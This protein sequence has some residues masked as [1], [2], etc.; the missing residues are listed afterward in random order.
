MELLSELQ[1]TY[2]QTLPYFDL[3]EGKLGLTYGPGKWNVQEL[4]HHIVDAETVMYDRIRRTLSKPG[5]VIWGFDQ[6]A[7]VTGLDYNVR[8]LSL[9]KQMYTAVRANI[10][11]LAE[12]HYAQ[13]SDYTF[14]HSETGLRTLKDEFDKVGWHNAHHLRQIRQALELGI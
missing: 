5:Q 9:S 1:H 2:E 7:W 11:Y 10:Q 8:P 3:E 4:L 13:A 6:N 14:V 12:S